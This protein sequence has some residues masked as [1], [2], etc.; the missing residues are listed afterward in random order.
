MSTQP[1]VTTDDP[2]NVALID[3]DATE[4]DVMDRIQRLASETQAIYG[5]SA[6]E[7]G[8]HLRLRRI[9]L[10]LDQSWDLVRQRLALR[11][12]GRDPGQ[13]QVRPREV[14]EMYKG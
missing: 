10:E 14:V 13:A 2:A 11:A 5:R 7:P 4:D 3:G 1:A 8:D 12:A 9:R 6:A